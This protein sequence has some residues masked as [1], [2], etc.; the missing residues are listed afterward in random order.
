MAP[1]IA[2]APLIDLSADQL[3]VRGNQTDTI[4]ELKD[5]QEMLVQSRRVALEAPAGR[6]KTTTL[7]QIG[8]R[9]TSAGNLA[10]IV[11]LPSWTQSG[12]D[13]LEF[14]AGMRPFKA[15]SI[16]AAKLA[17]LYDSQHF[18]FLL[19]GWN[20]VAESDSNRALVALGSSSV[21]IRKQASSSP[22]ELIGQTAATRNNGSRKVATLHT[23]TTSAIR[24]CKARD[25]GEF[26]FAADR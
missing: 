24:G 18:I 9:C 17:K 15:R 11:D 8:E 5:M 1:R 26:G 7:T 12:K 23:E 6:G 2:G 22:L 14:I 19:N 4:L 3:G 21:S 13:I 16:D 10:F 25:P 20:E